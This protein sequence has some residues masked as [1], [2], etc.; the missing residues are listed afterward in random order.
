MDERVLQVSSCRRLWLPGVRFFYLHYHPR[1]RTNRI[2]HFISFGSTTGYSSHFH[3]PF[4][5][6]AHP[7]TTESHGEAWGFSLL[8]SGSFRAEVE[9]NP[10]GLVRAQI[11][12]H[13]AQLSW[14]LPPSSSLQSPEC[15]SVYSSA[16]MGGMSR[17][18]HR[19]YRQNL[20]RSPLADRPRPVLLNSWEG[21]YFDFDENRILEL[22][23][24]TADLGIRLFVMDDGWFGVKYPRTSDHA[25]LGDWT[26]NPERF[27]NG[28][29]SCVEKAKG[30][31]V[32]GSDEKLQFGIWVE[33]EMVNPKS[34]LFE[35]HPDWALQAAG[36]PLTEARNQLVLNLS[37]PQVQ[38]YIVDSITTLL[39]SAPI[40]YV[41][42]D[43]NRGIHE[44]ASPDVFHGYMLG[45]YRVLRTLTT[46]FPLVL[47]EGCASGGGRFDAGM[48][49]Y[50]PQSWT[51]DNT[52]PVDRIAIQFG[53][54]LAYPPSTMGAHVAKVPNETTHR[55]TSLTFRAHVAMMGGSFGFELDPG[56]DIPAKDREEIPELIQLAERVNPVV[57]GGD[58][59]RLR[60]PE[61]SNHPAALFVAADG[62][63][64]VLFAFQMLGTTV[65]CQP[66]VCLEGLDS[67]ARYRL[68]C[69]KEYSGATLMNGG[70]QF[71][72][73]GDYDSRVVYLEKV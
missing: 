50:F 47:W 55:V 52:D 46:R 63:S 26:P 23:K 70:L 39:Q 45:L 25:G 65:H 3:N 13:D 40:S 24:G 56:G 41:K 32:A 53:T 1:P 14:V 44:T 51:S 68:D 22:A 48:L 64:A 9:K 4:F 15:V 17:Q 42:W 54:S 71:Q 36:Y 30:F 7:A 20:I 21:V 16:G 62:R 11:G 61:E 34:E 12:L 38:D 2:Y 58:L 18:L 57:V 72:F 19:L 27:P 28:L 29:K 60:L 67:E 8:Y 43:N 49:P 10:Q 5:T 6:L 35:N 69:G 73:V 59:W 37:L 66:T 31:S 33:P